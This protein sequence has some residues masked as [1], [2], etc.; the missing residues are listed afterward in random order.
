MSK[1]ANQLASK[2]FGQVIVYVVEEV[3]NKFKLV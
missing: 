3:N 1:K 2:A